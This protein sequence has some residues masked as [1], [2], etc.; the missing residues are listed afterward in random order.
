MEEELTMIWIEI[1]LNIIAM[2]SLKKEFSTQ[3]KKLQFIFLN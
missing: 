2:H 1:S 3:I